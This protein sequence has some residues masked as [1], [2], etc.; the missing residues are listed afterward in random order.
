[1]D[2]V[3]YIICYIVLLFIFYVVQREK[4]YEINKIGTTMYKLKISRKM[5]TV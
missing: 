2:V 4:Y 3:L 1:M 5:L